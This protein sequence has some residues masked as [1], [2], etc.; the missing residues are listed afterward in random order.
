[1]NTPRPTCRQCLPSSST[2]EQLV[3]DIGGDPRVATTA[4]E[5]ELVSR[6]II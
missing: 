2:S 1:M 4:A 3:L 5:L 6:V